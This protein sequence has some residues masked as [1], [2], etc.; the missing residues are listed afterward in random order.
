MSNEQLIEVITKEVMA[1]LHTLNKKDENCKKKV[2][3]LENKESLSHSLISALSEKNCTVDCLDDVKSIDTF[4]AI[5]LQSITN[6]ELANL[7]LGIEG[8][9]KERM[10]V[11]AL[12]NGKDVYLLTDKI[13]YKKYAATSNKLLYNMYIDYENKIKSYGVR[14][15]ELKELSAC[16]EGNSCISQ[17][18]TLE[19]N[20]DIQICNDTDN[21]N[22]ADLTE[23]KLISEADIKNAYKNGITSILISP[24]SILTPLALD[25]VRTNRLNI[26]EI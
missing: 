5:I 4:E 23:K 7:S 15:V 21:K 6:G 1:R 25:F 16:L 10:A 2:L 3:V 19:D 11:R 9:L 26:N 24:K 20:S 8:S 22:D 13:E 12:L 17:N 14:F 18:K